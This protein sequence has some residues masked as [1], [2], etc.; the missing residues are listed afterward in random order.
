MIRK[1]LPKELDLKVLIHFTIQHV[2]ITRRN[3]SKDVGRLLRRG[4]RILVTGWSAL[5]VDRERGAPTVHEHDGVTLSYMISIHKVSPPSRK[6]Y[7][8]ELDEF[9]TVHMDIRSFKF[10][11]LGVGDHIS[12]L[13]CDLPRYALSEIF[14][15]L[16]KSQI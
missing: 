5:E 10:D 6:S 1:A 12:Q 16:V 11:R 9:N 13:A 2:M 8:A 3:G 7:Q 4:Q 15:S 14:I